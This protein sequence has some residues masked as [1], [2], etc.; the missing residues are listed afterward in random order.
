MKWIR[1]TAFV[2]LAL[3]AF[4]AMA[5]AQDAGAPPAR[6]DRPPMRGGPGGRGTMGGPGGAR[7]GGPGFSANPV[8]KDDA[9]KKVLDVLDEIQ[10]Q[11][12]GMSVP[13]DDGR[14][15]RLLA[16]STGAKHAVE[17]GT[18][19]GYSGIWTCLGLRAAGG[20]LTTFEIDPRNAEISRQNFKRA[21]VDSMVTL[22]EG[23]AHVEV[24]KLK[25]PI[26][27]VFIDADKEGYTDYL[28][29]LLPLVRPGGLVVAHNI[30][31]GMADPQFIQAITASPALESV[32]VSA[33]SGG[34][35]VSMKKR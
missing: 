32:F 19:H 6:G 35:S 3:G 2:Y 13:R 31:A 14:L 1:N 30:S 33:G 22:I 17:I 23:D 21:G 27:M 20:K 18:F 25:G 4:T 12:R 34:I 5:A 24:A 16:E 26:D 15:L 9:E 10:R 7:G 28:N 11:G 29:K 8:P